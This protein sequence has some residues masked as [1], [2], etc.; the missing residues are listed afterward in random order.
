M[1][2]GMAC[3][4]KD[5]YR[6]Y[7]PAGYWI[8]AR[9]SSWIRISIRIPIQPDTGYTASPDTKRHVRRKTDAEFNIRPDTGYLYAR[10]SSRIG[11]SVRILIQ[12]G[13]GYPAR[14]SGGGRML[15]SISGRLPDIWQ[16]FQSDKG[17]LS[18]YL[19]SRT[20]DIRPGRILNVIVGQGCW[21]YP[22]AGYL[23]DICPTF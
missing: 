2:R 9:L 17:Y 23:L 5:G 6:I 8:Y 19:S 18:E 22:P 20:P 12:P 14:L 15:N 11:I 1:L 13:T 4:A 7:Y 21:I 16:T 3:S 10:L